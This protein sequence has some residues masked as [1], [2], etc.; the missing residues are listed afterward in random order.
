MRKVVL[1]MGVSLD[2]FIEGPAREIDWHHVDDEFHTYVNGELAKMGAFL[3]GR[4]TYDLMVGFWP[5]AETD[6]AS[7]PPMVEFAG[8]WRD[9][10][11]IVYSRT[12]ERADSNT[13]IVPRRSRSS[14]SSP[15]AT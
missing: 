7:T 15:A 14:R 4:V 6:P 9:M 1:W 11:K 13:T 10:P 5:T 8:I 2:G 12:L 3:M